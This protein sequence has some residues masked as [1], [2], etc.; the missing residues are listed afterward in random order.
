M[1][2]PIGRW[3]GF[4][5]HGAATTQAMLLALGLIWQFAFGVKDHLLSFTQILICPHPTSSHRVGIEIVPRRIKVGGDT[6]F[7]SALVWPEIYVFGGLY[8]LNNT[9]SIK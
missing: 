7:C 8:A 4:L 2:G 9:C 3:V 6:L 1:H 5:D